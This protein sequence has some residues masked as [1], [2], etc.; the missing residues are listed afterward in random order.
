MVCSFC[1]YPLSE[2]ASYCE[3][4]GAKVREDNHPV[5]R[6][7]KTMLPLALVLIFNFLIDGA[8]LF[9]LIAIFR[10]LYPESMMKGMNNLLLLLGI[11]G[12]VILYFLY[13]KSF[14]AKKL[15]KIIFSA[16]IGFTVIMLLIYQIFISSH[17]NLSN[18]SYLLYSRINQ[19]QIISS[20]VFFIIFFGFRLKR[21]HFLWLLIIG[22]LLYI[23][24]GFT[25]TKFY[26]FLMDFNFTSDN[27]NILLRLYGYLGSF[28][29]LI[30][31]IAMSFAKDHSSG[32]V[33]HTL[34]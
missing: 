16:I 34:A 1:H 28:F 22:Y 12:K 26:T 33:S 23:I 14:E 4:C 18:N 21:N 32:H 9:F 8:F 5:Q 2:G 13:I 31:G 25:S 17:I 7:Q 6:H 11:S 27:A 30:F 19:I 3:H 24:S 29:L 15:E 20:Y 10:H